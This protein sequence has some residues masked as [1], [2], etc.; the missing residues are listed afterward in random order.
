MARRSPRQI[1]LSYQV[2]R[3]LKRKKTCDLDEL[4]QECTSYTWTQVFLE[5]DRMSR[6][7]ELRL[8]SKKAG[9]YSV[10]LPRAA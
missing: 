6:T 10:T 2:L 8:V 5:V 4:L 9:E 3:I 7:G 1:G